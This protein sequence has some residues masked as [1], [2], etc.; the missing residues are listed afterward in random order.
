MELTEAEKYRMCFR[1][2]KFETKHKAKQFNNRCTF[3]CAKIYKCP[4][5]NHFHLCSTPTKHK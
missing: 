1:K 2:R 4:V 5:C 3:K